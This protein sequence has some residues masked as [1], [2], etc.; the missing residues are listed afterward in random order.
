MEA[1]QNMEEQLY[2][3]RVLKEQRDMFAQ[4]LEILNASLGNLLNTK[5]TVENLRDIKEGEEILIPIGG[6]ISLKAKIMN[7]EKVLLYISQDII[8]EKNLDGSVEFLDKLVE[9][10]KEQIS[11]L[12]TQLQNLD[13]NLQAFSNAL[14][15][16]A[17]QQ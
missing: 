2:K 16:G 9:Q 8:V 15:K 17:P 7:P 5:T 3:F 10:H 14:Q 6:M 11:Y 13:M 12:G 4:Q 1:K